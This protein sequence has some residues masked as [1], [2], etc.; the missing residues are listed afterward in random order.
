MTPT[1]P[2]HPGAPGAPAPGAPVR[3]GR[4]DLGVVRDGRTPIRA[5]GGS[6][7]HGLPRQGVAAVDDR[8]EAVLDQAGQAAVALRRRRATPPRSRPVRTGPS[9]SR[10]TAMIRPRHCR[11]VPAQACPRRGGPSYAGRPAAS[12]AHRSA[13]GQASQRGSRAVQTRAPSSI[14][15]TAQVAAVALVVGQQLGGQV[16]L[17]AGHRRAAGTRPRRPPAP[18]P[19]ARWCRARRAGGRRRSSRSPRRC[20]RPTPGSA[21]SSS[22]AAGTSPSWR[23]TIADGRGVQPQ[24]PPRVAE[25]APH[26]HRLAGRLGGE[27]GR[28]RPALQPGVV[29]PAAPGRPASAGA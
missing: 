6:D 3:P 16:A 28:R 21:S 7:R 23:S 13:T 24:R 11:S 19:G 14:T 10:S 26:P 27:G 12:H 2:H 5:S 18:A 29:R 15:A 25:P 8:D 4:L 22:Y 20:S 17:G 9:A 1:D